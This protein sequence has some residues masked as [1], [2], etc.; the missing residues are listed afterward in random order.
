MA[1][2]EAE[3]V[4]PSTTQPNLAIASLTIGELL[5]LTNATTVTQDATTVILI[6]TIPVG[7][8]RSEGILTTSSIEQLVF[9][10]LPNAI[11][12]AAPV[13]VLLCTPPVV[14]PTSESYNHTIL[15]FDLWL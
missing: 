8:Q 15:W 1:M 9:F 4:V 2:I 7:S 6:S 5:P 13:V 3:P 10:P 11:T 12:V 14:A